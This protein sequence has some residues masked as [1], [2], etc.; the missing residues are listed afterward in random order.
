MRLLIILIYLYIGKG[1]TSKS[2]Y[3]L[4]IFKDNNT[5]IIYIKI[6]NITIVITSMLSPATPSG[7]AVSQFSNTS[8]L[9]QEWSSMVSSVIKSRMTK[10]SEHSEM[11]VS[12]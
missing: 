5:V 9:P 8:S 6:H 1:K 11:C 10:S 4:T 2:I 3:I 12:L 7:M